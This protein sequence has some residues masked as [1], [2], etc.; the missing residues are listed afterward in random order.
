MTVQVALL[1]LENIY[2]TRL[3]TKH[4]PAYRNTRC[5]KG[6][7]GRCPEYRVKDEMSTIWPCKAKT[8]F[9]DREVTELFKIRY[10]PR[11]PSRGVD[12]AQYHHALQMTTVPGEEEGTTIKRRCFWN[13]LTQYGWVN[14]SIRS[15]FECSKPHRQE[16]DFI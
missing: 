14:S 6:V 11:N 12:M 15:S 7:L 2:S 4:V 13:V 8:E 5:G 16:Q 10:T 1:Y 3:K 9:A